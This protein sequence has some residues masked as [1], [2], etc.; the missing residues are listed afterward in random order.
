MSHFAIKAAALMRLSLL[1]KLSPEERSVVV[2]SANALYIADDCLEGN[3]PFP[4][5]IGDIHAAE[6]VYQERCVL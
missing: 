3:R 5:T 4:L 1:E 6:K 2:S